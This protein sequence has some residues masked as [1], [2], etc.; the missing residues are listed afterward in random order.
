[1]EISSLLKLDATYF[2]QITQVFEPFIEPWVLQLNIEQ[3]VE[4]DILNLKIT[5]KEELICNLTYGM[6]LSLRNIYVEALEQIYAVDDLFE[7]KDRQ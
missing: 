6:A 3:K 1:M 2:N 7:A 4:N 5:G